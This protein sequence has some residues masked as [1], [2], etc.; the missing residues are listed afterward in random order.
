MW[1]RQRKLQR[2]ESSSRKRPWPSHERWRADRYS[3]YM[4]WLP[5]L[6]FIT[7]PVVLIVVDLA[8]AVVATS[9]SIK[10]FFPKPHPRRMDVKVI[11]CFSLLNTAQEQILIWDSCAQIS[12]GKMLRCRITCVSIIHS[13]GGWRWVVLEFRLPGSELHEGRNS[14]L[15]V[16]E[17]YTEARW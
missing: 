3:F 11:S 12:C 4:F 13:K 14:L 17:G 9:D 6:G 1:E 2:W 7:Q 15:S 5:Y 10:W 8:H 16:N